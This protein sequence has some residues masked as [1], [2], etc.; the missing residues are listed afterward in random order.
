MFKAKLIADQKFHS[1]RRRAII[2]SLLAIPFLA[3]INPMIRLSWYWYVLL[4]GILVSYFFYQRKDQREMARI[5]EDQ[6]EIDPIK[7]VV[8][9][10]KGETTT[11]LL[12]KDADRILVKE[13]YLLPDDEIKDIYHTMLS[14]YLRNFISI[15]KNN[16][17]TTFEFYLDSHFMIKQLQKIVDQ[18]IEE[19]LPVL[20]VP[21]ISHAGR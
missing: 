6:I 7:I 4:I 5:I 15:E 19:K 16:S 17:V 2:I 21:D 13:K 14:N 20:V 1:L 3:L 12:L 11:E 18:W 10:N 9:N 8:K